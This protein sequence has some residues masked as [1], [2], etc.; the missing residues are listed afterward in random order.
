MDTPEVY[1]ASL[2]GSSWK[3]RNFE[4]VFVG[5]VSLRYA[6]AHSINTVAVK[7]GADIG[8]DSII[9]MARALGIQSDL[10]SNLSLTL[11]ASEVTPLELTNAYATL[12]SGGLAAEPV[13]ITAVT[14]VDGEPIQLSEEQEPVQAIGAAEA[15]VVTSLLRSVIEEGTGKKALK[16]NRPLAGKT[17]TANQQRD[18]WFVG[19]SPDLATGVWVGFD[20]HSRMGTGWAQ[21][22]GT[23]LPIWVDFMEAALAQRPRKDFK[24]PAGVVFARVDPDNGLLA[25]PKMAGARL[26]VFV[27]GTEPRSHSI[28][29]GQEP[30]MTSDGGTTPTSGTDERIPEGLFR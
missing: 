4:R 20:D 5:A 18:G 14:D 28:R 22:A 16:L 13:F 9:S 27:E 7:I 25:S 10:T 23:A 29:E 2:R 30:D 24:A 3:P 12:A 11:G 17:G 8:V 21:G 19:Y 6:L 26:E 15:F 1:R